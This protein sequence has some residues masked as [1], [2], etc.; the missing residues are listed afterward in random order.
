MHRGLQARGDLS[1]RLVALIDLVA[2][3]GGPVTLVVLLV[4]AVRRF[5]EGED[6][7][8]LRLVFGPFVAILMVYLGS[9]ASISIAMGLLKVV[10]WLAMLLLGWVVALAGLAAVAGTLSTG[11]YFVLAKAMEKMTGER[12]E[13]WI[14]RVLTPPAARRCARLH[15]DSA[16]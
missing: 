6:L 8:G 1:R 7:N 10:G 3:L 16:A 13:H 2:L 4:R 14:R 15:F 12:L 9:I 5:L 11:L